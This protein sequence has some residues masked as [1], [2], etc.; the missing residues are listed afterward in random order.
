MSAR[1]AFRRRG[2]S[3]FGNIRPPRKIPSFSIGLFSRCRAR[4]HDK[5]VETGINPDRV[6][7][8]ATKNIMG[9]FNERFHP[10]DSIGYAYGI[11]HD[12]DNLHIHVA[13]CPRT[14]RGAYVG[15]ST[16]RNPA[17]GHKDQM[18]FLRSCFE[19]ENKR[20]E[21]ILASPQKLEEH[22][23]RRID[24]DKIVFSPRLNPSQMDALRNAQTAEAI[25]LQQL[26]Q[27]IRN[28]EASIAAKRKYFVLKRS[29]NFVSRLVGRRVPKAARVAEKARRRRRPSFAAGNATSSFQDQGG[30]PR[31]PQTLRADAGLQL[32]CQS[33]RH[34]PSAAKRT[35][36]SFSARDSPSDLPTWT[37]VRTRSMRMIPPSPSSISSPTRRRFPTRSEGCSTSSSANSNPSA[38]MKA[39]DLLIYIL[40]IAGALAGYFLLA[41]PLS[42]AAVGI[43]AAFTVWTLFAADA[44][45]KPILRLAGL[46]WSMEDFVRGWLI[47]GRTG[48]GKTQCA[49]NTITYQ[50]FQN[51]PHWGGVCL[52]QKGLYWEILVRMAAHFGRG[53]DL[54]LLQTRPLGKG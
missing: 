54:V 51:V 11:H 13:L 40:G 7:Q 17:S 33:N 49:I 36:N 12:T 25:R 6:L 24:S 43:C 16:A 2:S 42:W 35:L 8:S 19:R 27:S 39:S 26:Y 20:W 45:A 29:A 47:T 31:R 48:S 14:A 21:Q 15:C 30:I 52:D 10:A 46:S 1:G 23:S 37:V 5:L 4:L 38:P 22:L 18:E 53:G 9:K 41:P 32:L 28:L 50:I 3:T 44:A 34:R